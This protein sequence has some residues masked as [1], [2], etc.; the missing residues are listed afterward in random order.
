MAPFLPASRPLGRGLLALG[1]LLLAL[2]AVPCNA[3]PAIADCGHCTD[4][5]D[6]AAGHGPGEA[7]TCLDCAVDAA[8]AP[9]PA[10]D[11]VPPVAAP[12]APPAAPVVLAADPAPILL[13]GTAPRPPDVR[14][15]L[16]TRRLR[17]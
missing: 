11:R 1:A 2:V 6:H 14:P 3:T 9:A 13:P 5:A 17:L 4:S 15:Y 10:G 12:E 8:A 7:D 16:K